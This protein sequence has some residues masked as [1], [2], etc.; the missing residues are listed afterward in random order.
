MAK[1]SL[2]TALVFAL[3]FVCG[4]VDEKGDSGEG[5]SPDTGGNG[6]ATALGGCLETG[7]AGASSVPLTTVPVTAGAFSMGNPAG[8][9]AARDVTLTFSF[10]A[11]VTEVSQAQWTEVM[12]TAPAQQPQCPVCPVEG[13]SW[14]D[15]AAFANALSESEG[16]TACYTCT[17]DDSARTCTAP[18]DPY[19]CTGWRLPTEAEWEFMA[20]AG[21]DTSYAGDSVI[22]NVGWTVENVGR[23]CPVGQLKENDLG[24]FDLSGNVWEW[25]NDGHTETPT[26]TVD[27]KGDEGSTTRGMRGGSWFNPADQAQVWVRRGSDPTA[28][29]PFLGFRVV[30]RSDR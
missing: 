17:G 6:L 19:A 4:C 8:D 15:A 7:H 26:E 24:L 25:V 3:T 11:A 30:R 10:D 21:A 14:H 1:M 23:P 12:G 20:R 9:P 2:A 29:T 16:L 28:V 27:P 13:V 5:A 18:A 22:E